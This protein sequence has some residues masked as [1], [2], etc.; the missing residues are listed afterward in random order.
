MNRTI[1]ARRLAR[2][3]GSL[4]AAAGMTLM[5]AGPV[6]ASSHRE[7]PFI[8][9][10]PKV[11]GTDFYAFRSYE[12]G[13]GS[14]VTLIA[15]YQPLEASY[16][17]PNYF[18]MDPD[19]LYEIHVDNNGDAVEDLTFQFR[20]K[21]MH[22]NIALNVGGKSV[23]I[24]LVQAGSITD[25]NPAVQNV[26]E[27][28]SV[29]LV[30]GPRRGGSV[31]AISN[32]ANGA[33]RFDKPLDNIGNK[34][35]PDYPAYAAKFVYDINIPGCG[36]GRLFVGQRKDPFVVNLG[37]TFDLINIRYPAVEFNANAERS[38]PD[39]LSDANTTSLVLEVPASC[40]TRG[41]DP[42]IGAWTSASLRQGRLINPE[43]RDRE[44]GRSDAS[45]VGGAWTQVSRLG[46]P[47]VNEVIIGL[48]DKD[49]FNASS[50]AGDGQFA[51]Y[52]TNPTL[53]ALVEALFGAA[54]VKAPTNFPRT[55]LVTA[56]L[57]GIPG[58]NQPAQVTAAEM[59]RL[60]TSVAVVPKGMQ[61]RLG[62]IGGD[63]AGFPNGRRPGDDVVDVSLRVAMGLLC[64]LNNPAAFGCRAADAPAGGIHFTD[65]AYIDDGYID[66]AFP[67]LKTPLAGS[68]NG[69]N[70]LPADQ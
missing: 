59:L 27:S 61:N 60:N 65:G 3:S 55:D 36:A 40:L 9:E 70:G 52:V 31:Q 35:I 33:T 48:K 4:L 25:V 16:G 47:L 45:K 26:A 19:A 20:F 14:Y 12:P 2:L 63:V 43:P 8:T 56:F 18:T 24:P 42:V 34:T 54:G 68:P 17:G 51:D 62:V 22:R 38:A 30:R 21:T 39:S 41:S 46:M 11:D 5:A 10:H 49:R 44:A 64:T 32:A 7:A 67:Y 1:R 69:Q 50:P 53:P 28:Y 58:L 29:S 13:R 57:T 66:G 6:Q 15:N 37:E 23:A